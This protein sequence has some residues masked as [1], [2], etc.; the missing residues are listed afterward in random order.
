M[1][2]RVRKSKNRIF[3][4]YEGKSQPR[5]FTW[6][7]SPCWRCDRRKQ[8]ALA[9]V[10]EETAVQKQTFLQPSRPTVSSF[11]QHEICKRTYGRTMEMF[12]AHKQCLNVK[13]TKTLVVLHA[14]KHF[15]AKAAKCILGS[16]I[17]NF[18]VSGCEYLCLMI[19]HAIVLL[20][21]LS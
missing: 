3:H 17:W 7:S 14:R 19:Y 16:E 11:G 8:N 5:G 13:I 9:Q 6:H 2:L 20:S 1:V 12:C 18:H 4:N 21:E 15:H 10:L